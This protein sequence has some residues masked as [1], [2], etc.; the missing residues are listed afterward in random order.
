MGISGA[1]YISEFLGAVLMFI[2]FIRATSPIED[3]E[4]DS[5]I[6]I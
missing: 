3:A 1:L 6:Q 4:E 5:P 2:G